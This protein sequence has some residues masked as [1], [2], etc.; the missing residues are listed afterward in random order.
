MSKT[1]GKTS[2]DRKAYIIA[3]ARYEERA[4]LGHVVRDEP[5]RAFCADRGAYAKSS[6][7]C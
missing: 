7:W 3:D 4:G 1:A 5:S 6:Q 2:S